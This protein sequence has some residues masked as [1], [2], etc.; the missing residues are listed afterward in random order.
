MLWDS[1]MCKGDVFGH[2][3]VNIE[4]GGTGINTAGWTWK[5]E[6]RSLYRRPIPSG[7][8]S[9]PV[10]INKLGASSNIAQSSPWGL[11]AQNTVTN[12]CLQPLSQVL[13]SD[14]PI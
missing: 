3:R 11:R 7:P 10:V 4:V 14:S 8:S 13:L 1:G 2:S 6:S 5:P 9:P 12:T